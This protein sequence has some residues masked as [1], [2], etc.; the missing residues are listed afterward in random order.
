MGISANFKD[1]GTLTM[2]AQAPGQSESTVD[3]TWSKTG[4][5]TFDVSVDDSDTTMT[6]S[7][8]K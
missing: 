5:A 4:D 6:L 1:D 7:L 3:G 2:S 8:K